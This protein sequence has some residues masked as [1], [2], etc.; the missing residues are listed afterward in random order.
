M[1][2]SDRPHAQGGLEFAGGISI[3]EGALRFW[4]SRSSGPGGQA[5]NKVNT[6]AQVRV[7]VGAIRGLS[8]QAAGRL[9]SLA[10]RRLTRDDE[11]V[12]E[13]QTHRSQLDNKLACIEK[14]R[15]L[16]QAA[17]TRPKVRRKSKP[18]RSMIEKRLA[19]K[20]RASEKKG[21]RRRDLDFD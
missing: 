8:D 19:S 6:R 13:A 1:N 9:R 11:I 5:V 4:Y 7:A 10:G 21:G 17:I 14:L 18:T 2:M 16:V 15:A 20:R 12:L 3:D